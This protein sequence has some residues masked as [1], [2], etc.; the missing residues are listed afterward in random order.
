MVSVINH[1]LEEA[2]VVFYVVWRYV[3]YEN[4]VET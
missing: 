3:G 4:I 1:V 2:Y